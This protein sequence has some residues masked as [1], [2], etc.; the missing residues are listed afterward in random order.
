MRP[1]L[2]LPLVLA[3]MVTGACQPST[4]APKAASTSD[5]TPDDLAYADGIRWWI[6]EVPEA[7]ADQQLCLAFMDQQGVVESRPC[8]RVKSGDRVKVVLSGFNEWNLRFSL[9]AGDTGYRATMLN[10]FHTLRGPLTEEP[11]GARKRPGDFLMK[12]SESNRV[13]GTDEPLSSGEV[14]LAL[15]FQKEPQLTVR[16]DFYEA[17][18][19]RRAEIWKKAMEQG[20]REIAP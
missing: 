5:L 7:P 4:P 17:A 19:A 14:G 12:Q 6:V 13:S 2:L 20:E 15:V 10:H 18:N 9:F 16:T 3:A 11:A 1:Y 8:L